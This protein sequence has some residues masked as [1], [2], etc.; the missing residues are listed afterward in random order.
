MNKDSGPS[1]YNSPLRARQ[2]QQT[3][4]LILSAVAT[5]LRIADLAAVT[6]GEVARVSEVTERTIYRHFASR[7]D[8]LRAFWKWQLEKSGGLNVIAP[9]TIDELMSNIKRLFAS[10][11]E[12]EGVIR[13]VLSSAEGREM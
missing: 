3:H 10:L 9:A 4:D 7:E 11:D 5:I 13:A 12:D 8:L 6:F 2:K 1:N